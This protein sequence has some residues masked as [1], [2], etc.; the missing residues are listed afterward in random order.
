MNVNHKENFKD[1]ITFVHT[2]KIEGNW[3][4]LKMFLRKNNVKSREWVE[5]YVHEW[6]FKRNIGNTFEKCWNTILK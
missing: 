2:N 4:A 1:P 6:C 3:N 5:S